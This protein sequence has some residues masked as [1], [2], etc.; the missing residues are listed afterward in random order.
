[1]SLSS[2]GTAETSTRWASNHGRG[3]RQFPLAFCLRSSKF[4]LLTSSC[5]IS[6]HDVP[7]IPLESYERITAHENIAHAIEAMQVFIRKGDVSKFEHA[8]ALY[9]ASARKRQEPIE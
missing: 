4:A 7:E 9:V 2:H 3:S 6:N 1:M 8:V 5:M